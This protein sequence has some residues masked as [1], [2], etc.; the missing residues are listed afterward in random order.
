MKRAGLLI[1]KAGVVFVLIILVFLSISVA[2]IDRT[3]PQEEAFYREMMDEIDQ[4]ISP[5]PI[6]DTSQYE[7][8]YSKQSITPS[9]TTATAGYVKRKGKHFTSIRD[10]VFVRTMIIKQARQE[11]ALVSLDMLI[12]PPI[13]FQRLEK[14]LRDYGFPMEQVYLGTTHTHNSV[15]NWDDHLVGE[16]YAGEFNPELIDFMVRQIVSGLDQARKNSQKASMRYGAVPVRETVNNRLI[17]NGPVDSLFHLV[18]IV[19]QDGSKG[20]FA[21]SAFC[22]RSENKQGFAFIDT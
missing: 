6:S 15:G 7:V 9:F 8:G 20:I 1:L 14:A 4:A 13:L 16:I 11:L 12:I 3:L 2:P 10:S 19:R 17:K 22:Y 5:I 18:E 21:S